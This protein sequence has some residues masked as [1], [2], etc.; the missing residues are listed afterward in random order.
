[1]AKTLS[2]E[3]FVALRTELLKEKAALESR[4][5]RINVA[6]SDTASP[7]AAKPAVKTRRP[8]ARVK[9][10]LSLK[11]AAL[12]VTRARPLTRQEIVKAVKQIGYKFKTKDPLNSLNMVLY[13]S[14]AMKNVGGKFSPVK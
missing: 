10:K 7:R 12:Q 13:S 1:M 6:L 2:I 9:N 3:K 8:R 11:E 14:K 4:L 5:A